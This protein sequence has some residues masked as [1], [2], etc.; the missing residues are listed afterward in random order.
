MLPPL[1]VG[2][3]H[4]QPL[5]GSGA[6]ATS[7]VARPDAVVRDGNENYTPLWVVCMDVVCTDVVCMNDVGQLW[8]PV[9]FEGGKDPA[10]H[11]R[12]QLQQRPL[13]LVDSRHA[14]STR[15][16]HKVFLPSPVQVTHLEDDVQPAG[17]E[18]CGRLNGLDR[19]RYVRA[20]PAFAAVAVKWSRSGPTSRP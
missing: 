20:R 19:E 3:L 7:Q 5:G 14:R 8:P 2:A 11:V 12:E 4:T 1:P 15:R 18:E 16:L 13:A 10:V 17:Q 9:V 6:W